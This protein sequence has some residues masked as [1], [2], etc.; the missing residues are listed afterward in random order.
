MRDE[1][2]AEYELA[3]AHVDGDAPF[4]ARFARFFTELRDPLVAIY[5]DDPRF[6][7]Q[8]RALLDAMTRCAAVREPELRRLDHEREITP[9]WLQREQAVGYVTYVDRFA[10]T[11]SGVRERLGY[12]RELGV[13]YLHLMPLLQA[14]PEPN[15]GG[16]AVVDYGAVEPAL[17]TLEELRALAED[18]RAA[19]MALCIDVVLNHTAR[20]HAWAQAALAGD[21][22]KLAYYR[23]FT[24][25]AE[26]DAY[27]RTLPEVFPDGAPGNFTWVPE[28]ERWVWTTFNDYQWD[29]DYTN[30]EVFRAMAEVMLDLAATGVDV[31]RLDAVPFLWKRIGTD[32]QNQPEVHQLL[33]A[34]RA[35]VR[36]V[37]PAVAF[38]AEA[39]VSPRDLV[40]YLGAGRHEGKECDL[41][42][43]NV[44]MVL[45]WSSLATRRVAL[46]TKTLQS[47][48]P[49]PPGAGWV[50]YVRCHDDIGWAITEE[51]A[52][53]VGEDGQAH[54]R[55]LADFYAGDFPGT[56]ARGARFQVNEA[57]GDARTSGTAASLAGLEAGDPLAVGRLLLLHA[58]AFA[59]GGLPLIYMGDELGLCNDP[60]WAADAA[61]AGDNRW[62]HRPPMDWA[63]AERR[64]DP[65]SAEGRLW[66]GLQRLV[67][68]RRGT[69]A[70]HAQGSVEAIWT[71]NDHVFGLRREHAGDRLLLLANFSPE[72][73]RVATEGDT[74]VLEPYECAWLADPA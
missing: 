10:G 36:I 28:L 9:D 55:F 35:L 61:H 57:T 29:L 65:A 18:M 74:R 59:Y 15:D 43:H 42:Y 73:Q 46:M 48:P 53:A 44:L 40:G 47:M 51:D 2:R 68:L 39:I 14:R 69:R 54:R 70:V 33:Q 13:S 8:W 64:H 49:V 31:L 38:K 11:L 32:S 6:P 12:L 71:G 24:D 16:Y 19:G 34:F 22:G 72:P 30:P 17:G 50:T 45:L 26:P 23:T 63:A 25:R 56:F 5:G 52:A 62:M 60:A 4:Q 3:L 41:A 27:E 7:A 1:V 58:V 66:A 37:A 21:A 67:A 20:E